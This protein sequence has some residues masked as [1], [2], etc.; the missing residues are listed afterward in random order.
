[1]NTPFS[2]AN[3]GVDSAIYGMDFVGYLLKRDVIYNPLGKIL[4]SLSEAPAR[5]K[6]GKTLSLVLEYLL[7]HASDELVTDEMLM[8]NVWDA[9]GL[10]SSSQRLWQVMHNLKIKLRYVGIDDS[11]ILR[12]SRRGYLIMGENV[13]VLSSSPVSEIRIMRTDTNGVASRE[14]D[15]SLVAK[16]TRETESK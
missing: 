12:I 11:F 8:R 9:N 6:L 7:T 3:P 5:V 15:M 10:R 2:E 14:R 4:L 16:Q 1:M 13:R